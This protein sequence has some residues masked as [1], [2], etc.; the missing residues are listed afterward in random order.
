MKYILLF[1]ISVFLLTSCNSKKTYKRFDLLLA[2]QQFSQTDI[3]N[4]KPLLNVFEFPESC[5]LGK[6]VYYL[7]TNTSKIDNINGKSFVNGSLL[8]SDLSGSIKTLN[9]RQ[10]TFIDKLQ[11]SENSIP[12]NSTLTVD[13]LLNY[14]TSNEI[15]KHEILFLNSNTKNKEVQFMDTTYKIFKTVEDIHS[16]INNR[17]CSSKEVI[18][19]F[20]VFYNVDFVQANVNE[21][22]PTLP[23]DNTEENKVKDVIERRVMDSLINSVPRRKQ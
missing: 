12:S 1:I 21:V 14:V 6:N 5:G 23:S 13:S 9:D 17:L 3:G 4:L 16:L 8:T 22:I 2:T 19:R 15:K 10:N 20:L 11:I 7:I 18:P